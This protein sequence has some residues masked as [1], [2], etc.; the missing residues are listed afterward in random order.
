MDAGRQANREV[1][2][3]A[4]V[5]A[6]ITN[7]TDG[8]WGDRAWLHVFVDIEVAEGGR[9]S[10]ISF[11]LAQRPGGPVER[12]AFRLTSDTKR[13]FAALADDMAGEDGRWTSARLAVERD[14]RY[15]MDYRYDPPF[16]L[17]GQLIDRRFEDYTERWLASEAGARVRRP[18]RSWW[19]RMTGR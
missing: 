14:G 7:V 17:G 5:T 18:A 3:V 15:A 19:R 2:I 12:V 16:R 10:S 11:A 8:E 9:T 1:A 13:L 6:G 4:G